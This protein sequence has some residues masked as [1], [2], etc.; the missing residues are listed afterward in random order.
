MAARITAAGI[1]MAVVDPTVEAYARA[2]ITGMKKIA[3]PAR[4]PIGGCPKGPGLRRAEP[5]A[6]DP[7]VSSIP[8]RPITGSPHIPILGN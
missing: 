7:D 8:P 6:M 5:N 2:P 3:R 1:S 4:G